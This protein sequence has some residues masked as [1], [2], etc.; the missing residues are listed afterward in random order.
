MRA[1]GRLDRWNRAPS[2]K[3]TGFVQPQAP[4]EHWHIDIAYVN[5]AAEQAVR[6]VFGSLKCGVGGHM[7]D[8]HASRD[9]NEE[10]RCVIAAVT[11]I[12]RNAVEMRNFRAL[13]TGSAASTR[14][15][16]IC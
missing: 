7:G 4:H 12:R 14:W 16:R 1:A 3:G 15:Y 13:R 5:A 11:R 6:G 9:A 10:C 8:A 2:R